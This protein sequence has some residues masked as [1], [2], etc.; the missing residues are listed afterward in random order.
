MGETVHTL[1]KYVH[2]YIKNTPT[3]NTYNKMLYKACDH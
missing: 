3:V 1:D 2:T